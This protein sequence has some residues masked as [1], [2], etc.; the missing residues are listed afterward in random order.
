MYILYITNNDVNS[1]RRQD[2]YNI[3]YDSVWGRRGIQRGSHVV[4]CRH[5]KPISDEEAIEITSCM[6]GGGVV[7]IIIIYSLMCGRSSIIYE[8]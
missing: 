5:R 8:F 2:Y 6:R 3:C 7:F 4:V 1:I